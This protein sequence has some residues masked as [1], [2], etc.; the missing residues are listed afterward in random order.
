[1]STTAPAGRLVERG[2]SL[3]PAGV[4]GVAGSF[5]EGDVVEVRD[6]DGAVVARGMVLSRRGDAARASSASAHA[7]PA[8]RTSP[9]R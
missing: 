2:T 9:T 1:M 3:L 7:R 8:R 4:I 6:L 5:D